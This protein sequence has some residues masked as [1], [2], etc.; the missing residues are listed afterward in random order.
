M[1]T[2]KIGSLVDGRYRIEAR[3]GHGGMAEVYEAT[4]IINK[5][6]V[7]IK[8]I[9]EDV[10]KN[11]I[12]LRRFQNEA[13]IASSLNHPNIVKVYN[14][15]TIEG[16]PYIANEFIRG[17]SMK[18]MLDFRTSIPIAEAVSYMLQLTSALFYAHQHNIIHRDIKP[19]NIFVMPDG[20]IKLG[21]F[22]I[23]QAGGVD[24]SFTKTSEIIG[25]VHYLAPEI[26]QG[27][28]ASIQSDIYAAGVTFYE[29]LTGHV[30]FDKDTPVNVA[31]AHVKE[32]FPPVKKYVPNCPK[33]IE[34]IIANATKKRLS[35]RY[36][37]ADEFYDDLMDVSKRPEILKEKK[38]LISRIFGFK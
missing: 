6:R 11:P 10:M 19:H 37:G 35:E 2:I 8:M 21:D 26:S 5:R 1:S 12:N 17:Q 18:E 13:T 28:P 38:P 31:V 30:P 36:K 27:K 32:R 24:D 29:L 34:K 20:T 3:I 14:H 22:G 25:S 15:G 7:A 23:A 9:R 4:D 33:E 16:R